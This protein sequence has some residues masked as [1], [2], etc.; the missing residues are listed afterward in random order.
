MASSGNEP[1]PVVDGGSLVDKVAWVTGASR[2]LGRAIAL[3]LAQQGARVA[4]TAR[5]EERLWVLKGEVGEAGGDALVAAGSVTDPDHIESVGDA[6]VEAWGRIDVLVNNAGVSPTLTRSQ[7]VTSDEW[8]RVVDVNLTGAFFC[9]QAAARR[10]SEGGSLV[11]VSSI[12]GSVGMP[13]LAAYS[14][15]KGGLEALTRTL[16]L[17]WAESGIRVNAVAPGYFETDMTADLRASGRWRQH[18]LDAIPMGRFGSENEIIPAVLFLAS[19]ASSYMTGAT[20]ALDG[21][22]TAR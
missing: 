7:E 15:T 4:L 11:N 8:Q 13:R 16:A 17:E 1:T 10:M 22:W 9:A 20:L 6:I 14:A 19:E 2:G 3:G 21:G 12:H 5:D 18:L